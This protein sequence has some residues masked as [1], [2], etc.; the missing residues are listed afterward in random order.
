MSILV[1]LEPIDTTAAFPY[2]FHTI[3]FNNSDRATLYVN[4]RKSQWRWGVVI[5]LLKKTGVMVW[6]W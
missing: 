6:A 1:K 3:A 5:K 4:L 2:L